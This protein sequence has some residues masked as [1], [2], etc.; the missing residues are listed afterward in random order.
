[1]RRFPGRAACLSLSWAVLSLFIATQNRMRYDDIKSAHLAR[2]K[3]LTLE[4]GSRRDQAGRLIPAAAAYSSTGT[5]AGR[6]AVNLLSGRIIL[7]TSPANV[8]Q[9]SG[10]RAFSAFRNG[11]LVV[12]DI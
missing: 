1:M 9:K 6:D 11:E 2:L 10:E 7:F 12:R 5:R 4:A 3:R 8:F